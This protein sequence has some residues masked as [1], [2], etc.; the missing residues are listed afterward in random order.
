MVHLQHN[1]RA[2]EDEVRIGGQN[3]VDRTAEAFHRKLSIRLFARSDTHANS[4]RAELRC[5]V[6]RERACECLQCSASCLLNV[7]DWNT[8]S[9]RSTADLAANAQQ[10]FRVR[11]A[12]RPRRLRAL[13]CRCRTVEHHAQDDAVLVEPL[14]ALHEAVHERV[15]A[16]HEHE[17]LRNVGIMAQ[18]VEPAARI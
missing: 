14:A 8:F 13:P 1:G 18:C 15:D 5:D 7:A 6:R 2:E 12:S 3:S 11:V 4:T 10:R 9:S 16:V 17:L